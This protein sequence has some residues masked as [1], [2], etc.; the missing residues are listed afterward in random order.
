MSTS[1]T[2][3]KRRCILWFRGTDLRLHDNPIVDDAAKLVAAGTIHEVLPVYIYD[4]RFF[5]ATPAGDPRTGPHRA[6]FLL[7]SVT[8]LRCSLQAAGNDLLVLVGHPERLLPQLTAGDKPLVLTTA[9]VASEELHIER[10]VASALRDVRGSL[11]PLWGSTLYH[12]DDLPYDADLRDLPDVFTPFRNKVESR[13]AVR[14][15]L[16]TPAAGA[17]P[18]AEVDVPRFSGVSLADLDAAL[19]EHC[20]P[21]VKPKAGGPT[22]RIFR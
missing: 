13:C 5:A 4:P 1:M 10:C 12:L 22:V 21:L 16:R 18:P 11:K 20:P 9:E 15:P 7:D 14:A 19:P 6:Q 3:S 17:L 8:D 2:A